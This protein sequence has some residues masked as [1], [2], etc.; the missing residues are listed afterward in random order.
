MDKTHF[1]MNSSLGGHLS[2]FQV[3]ILINSAAMN[4]RVQT[5]F[6]IWFSMVLDKQSELD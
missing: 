5:V 1:S 4:L 3:L 2:Y 6:D